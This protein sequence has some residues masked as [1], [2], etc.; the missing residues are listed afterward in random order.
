MKRSMGPL[1]VA[2]ALGTAVPTA[3]A[4]RS[5]A[6]PHT[7]P[8][9]RIVFQRVLFGQGRI[10]LFT[11]RSDG[12]D[13]RQLTY[14]PRGVETG[15]PDWSPDGRWL[16]YMW[17]SMSDESAPKHLF[18]MRADGTHRRDLSKG[19]CRRDHCAGE[20]D[21]A[22]SPDGDRFAFVRQTARPRSIFV[23]RTDGTHRRRVTTPPSRRFGDS[24]PSWSPAGSGLVFTRYDGARGRSSLFIVGLDGSGLRRITAWTADELVRPDWSPDGRWIVFSREDERGLH[25]LHLIHPDGTGLH[26]I[27]HAAGIE[28]IWP[29]FSPDG[30][31]ITAIRVPGESSENDV[32]VMSRDGT[33]IRS[34]TASLSRLPAE[35]L[36]DWGTG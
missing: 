7:P 27:T 3:G 21:P 29:S 5:F 20:E 18:V 1:I 35:G 24:A 9:G 10:A 6:N 13:A 32:Y 11:V 19:A 26:A 2:L 12:T 31:M 17:A 15:R 23:M 30:T 28:W 36:P 33:G 4:T 34:V 8:N 16:A 25:Q 22:W 14:P